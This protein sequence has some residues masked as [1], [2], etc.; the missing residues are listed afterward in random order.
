MEYYLLVSVYLLQ[1]FDALTYF[2]MVTDDLNCWVFIND[3]FVVNQEFDDFLHFSLSFGQKPIFLPLRQ[4]LILVFEVRIITK[5]C[6]LIVIVDLIQ[7]QLQQPRRQTYQLGPVRHEVAFLRQVVDNLLQ[8]VM[9]T[10]KHIFLNE[11]QNHLLKWFLTTSIVLDRFLV[12]L[13]QK[14]LIGIYSRHVGSLR[15]IWMQQTLFDITDFQILFSQVAFFVLKRGNENVVE[16]TRWIMFGGEKDQFFTEE[17]EVTLFYLFGRLEL[18]A[19]DDFVG[20]VGEDSDVVFVDE[21]DV[22]LR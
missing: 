4:L 13:I 22:E 7:L 21:G 6:Y 2:S 16:C 11:F 19:V 12:F 20:S 15:W 5:L 14:Q 8:V 10:L 9:Q 1:V 18:F 17:V 3:R